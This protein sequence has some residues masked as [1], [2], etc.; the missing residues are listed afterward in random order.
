M[1]WRLANSLVTL[2]AQINDHAPSRSIASDG[3]IGDP[4][5]ASRPSRHNPNNAGVVCAL[6]ITHD[7]DDGCD[8]HA[9][10][11]HLRVH[12]HPELDYMISRGRIAMR[13]SWTWRIYLG[14]NPHNLHVHFAVGEGPDSE[15]LPPYDST[16]PWSLPWHD[17]PTPIPLGEDLFCK[18]GDDSDVVLYWKVKLS[19]IGLFVKTDFNMDG[20][21]GQGLVDAVKAANELGGSTASGTKI[22]SRAAVRIERLW[23]AHLFGV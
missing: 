21:Y 17:E 11:D 6:D 16:Q 19:Q 7:P 4:A 1:A 5:H 22:D 9:I 14:S 2:R 3:T 10:A 12:P 15:P 8:A 18:E 23:V 20:V 13:P